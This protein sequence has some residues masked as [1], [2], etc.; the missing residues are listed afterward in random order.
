MHCTEYRFYCAEIS[1]IKSLCGIKD[2]YILNLLIKLTRLPKWSYHTHT[3]EIRGFIF[4]KFGIIKTNIVTYINV[5]EIYLK[6]CLHISFKNFVK[7]KKILKS[8]ELATLA[9]SM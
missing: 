2:F 1:F 3:S 5:V 7:E 8:T 4:I 6:C 9:E